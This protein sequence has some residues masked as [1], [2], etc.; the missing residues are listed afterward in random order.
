MSG[1]IAVAVRPEKLKLSAVE[2]TGPGLIKSKGTVR[3]V[4]WR[5]HQQ[6]AV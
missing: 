5:R 1:R 2:P 6:V 3:D 4:A